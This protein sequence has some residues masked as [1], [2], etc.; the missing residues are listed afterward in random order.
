KQVGRLELP[1]NGLRICPQRCSGRPVSDL[2]SKDVLRYNLFGGN[3]SGWLPVP[4]VSTKNN[5][6]VFFFYNREM[7]R[8]TA[9]SGGQNFVD[10]PGPATLLNGDFSPFITSN[11]MQYAPQFNVGTVFQPGTLKF[12]SAGNIIDGVPYPGNIVPP[13]QWKSTTASYMKLFT[14]IP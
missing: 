11:K 10:I 8:R 1:R 6:K 5:K 12:D 2:P 3:F 14:G 13:S 7:T 4:K 9:T